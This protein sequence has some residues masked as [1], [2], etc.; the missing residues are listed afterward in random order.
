MVVFLLYSQHTSDLISVTF[1]SIV[2]EIGQLLGSTAS[3]VTDASISI[4]PPDAGHSKAFQSKLC[5]I[6]FR[7]RVAV[8]QTLPLPASPIR[9]DYN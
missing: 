2:E 4:H 6:P 8:F 1:F 5:C 3:Y 7:V 9:T